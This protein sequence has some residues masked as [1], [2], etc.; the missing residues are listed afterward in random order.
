MRYLY[1]VTF[2]FL[3]RKRIFNVLGSFLMRAPRYNETMGSLPIHL[4]NC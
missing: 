4:R 3:N 2:L 1:C